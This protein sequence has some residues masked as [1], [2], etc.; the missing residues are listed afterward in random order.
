MGAPRAARRTACAHG[1]LCV[2]SSLDRAVW[3]MGAGITSADLISGFCTQMHVE[4]KGRMTPIIRVNS[5][6]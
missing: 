2:N 1:L 6:L 4:E 5:S 3:T